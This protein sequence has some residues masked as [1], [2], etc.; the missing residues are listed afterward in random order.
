M[1]SI[2]ASH[3]A[4]G[5]L[6]F[7]GLPTQGL[8]GALGG[9]AAQQQAPFDP[10]WQ[11]YYAQAALQQQQTAMMEQAMYAKPKPI[12]VDA[13]TAEAI[14]FTLPPKP[15]ALDWLNEQVASVRCRL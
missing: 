14:G 2:P 9:A 8:A 7:F 4:K 3:R 15:T 1:G 5:A 11:Q 6:G 10:F 12:K 13:A